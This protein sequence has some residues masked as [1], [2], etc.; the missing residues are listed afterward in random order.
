[1]APE[2]RGSAVTLF[3]CILFMG[4][5]LGILVLAASLDRGS[6]AFSF[7]IAGLGLL[8]LG[9]WVARHVQARQPNPEGPGK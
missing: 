3:A 9:W 4:Q 2:S 1:M 5:S 6:L 8:I 7:S